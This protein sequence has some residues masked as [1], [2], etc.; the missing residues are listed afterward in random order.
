MDQDIVRR[1]DAD[2]ARNG[3]VEQPAVSGDAEQT[4]TT[5]AG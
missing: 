3:E 2:V 5:E 4:P 1:T